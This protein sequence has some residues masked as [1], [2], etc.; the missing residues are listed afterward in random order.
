M[1]VVSLSDK[2]RP[3][4]IRRLWLQASSAA[5]VVRLIK[6]HCCI[7]TLKQISAT[8]REAEVA[9]SHRSTWNRHQLQRSTQALDGVLWLAEPEDGLN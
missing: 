6:E 2:E 9:M 4:Q 7:P 1:K 3:G 5:F 8:K